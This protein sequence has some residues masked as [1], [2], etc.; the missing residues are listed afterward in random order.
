[1]IKKYQK[2]S[3]YPTYQR[4]FSKQLLKQTFENLKENRNT[5][6]NVRIL[7]INLLMYNY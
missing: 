7:V 4:T 3:L 5:E 1:M 6:E 2:I